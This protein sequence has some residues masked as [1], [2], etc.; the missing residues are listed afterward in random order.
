MKKIFVPTT[1][2]LF[3]LFPNL[4]SNPIAITYFSE[5][6]F[7]STG[8]QLELHISHEPSPGYV[9]TLDGWY[10]TTSSGKAYFKTGTLLKGYTLITNDNLMNDLFIN[11]LGD[12]LSIFMNDQDSPNQTIIFGNVPGAIIDA[13]IRGQSLCSGYFDNSP[14]LGF[15]NDTLDACGKVSGVIKDSVGNIIRKAKIVYSYYG[16]SAYIEV[17]GF[18]YPDSLGQFS[19]NILSG[20]HTIFIDTTYKS[21]TLFSDVLKWMSFNV[22]PDSVTNINIILPLSVSVERNPGQNIFFNLSQNYPNPFNPSTKINFTIPEYSFVSLKVF[23]L[24][25]REIAVLV[26]EEKKPGNYEVSF[27]IEDVNKNLSSGLY[28]YALHAGKYFS[29]RK[30]IIIK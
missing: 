15:A 3:V 22:K 7:D 1:I 23:D 17:Y 2:L 9:D 10:L 20:N 25:G 27:S 16:N 14:T 8:W 26:N 4:R 21:F 29:T 6:Y 28:F 18:V 5:L 30:M 12:S 24:L 13:P 19:F 11:P